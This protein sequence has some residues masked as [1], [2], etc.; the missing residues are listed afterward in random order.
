MTPSIK[1]WKPVK[2]PSQPAGIAQALNKS[3]VTIKDHG[4][5]QNQGKK[6]ILQTLP[7]KKQKWN[8]RFS[9]RAHLVIH[10]CTKVQ[11]FL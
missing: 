1:L 9:L 2:D 7:W 5:L 11:L 10:R 3:W 6:A 8:E 4:R